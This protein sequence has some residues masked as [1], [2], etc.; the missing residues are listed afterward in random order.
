MTGE[1]SGRV[2][3]MG[4][5]HGSRNPHAAAVTESLLARAGELLEVEAHAAYLEDFASP[6]IPE[7]AGTLASHG[8]ESIIAVPLLFTSAYH[9]T[10]DTPEEIAEAERLH[11]VQI[12]QADVLGTGEDLAAILAAHVREQEGPTPAG[13]SPILFL[14]VGSSHPGAN[15]AVSALGDRL[16][17]I[18]QREVITRFATCE[19]R[20][21]DFF[22]AQGEA[23]VGLLLPLFTAPGKLL[24]VTRKRAEAAGWRTL[25]HLGESLAPL[26]AERYKAALSQG[27]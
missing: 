17:N 24:D 26:V 12:R 20:A 9:A 7:V 14:G 21:K 6:S 10:E 25:P 3:L 22:A 8:Y 2:A 16:G 27:D 4:V 18:M 13:A 23:G 5:A 19:P 15:E 1:H 11:G